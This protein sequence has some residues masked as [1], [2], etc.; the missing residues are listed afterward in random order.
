MHHYFLHRDLLM[1]LPYVSVLSRPLV[2]ELV[3]T[4][5]V[6]ALLP[7]KVQGIYHLQDALVNGYPYWDQL[8]GNN[9]LWFGKEYEFKFSWWYRTN[10]QRSWFLGPR[11]RLGELDGYIIGP[12][13][14]DEPPTRIIKGWKYFDNDWKAAGNSE[15]IFQDISPSEF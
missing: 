2:M 10:T 1:S 15:I 4:G 12:K 9:S 13:G 7:L 8:N 14:I 11:K 6:K 5:Q 3:L